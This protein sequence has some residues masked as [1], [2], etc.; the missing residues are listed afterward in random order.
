[1]KSMA[2]IIVIGSGLAGITVVRELRKL[3]AQTPVIMLTSDDG[4]FYSKPNLSNAFAAGKSAAQ[5]VASPRETLAAQLKCDIQSHQIVQ[6]IDLERCVVETSSGPQAYSQLVMAVGAQPIRLP[7]EGSAAEQILSVNNLA[8]Y[9]RFRTALEG[10]ATPFRRVTLLGAGLIGCE[11]ANDLRGA[12]YEVDVVDLA[13]QPLGRLLPP[14]AA[15]Y[16]RRRLEAGGVRFHLGTSVVRVDRA[17][18]GLMLLDREGGRWVTDIV[19]SAVGLRPETA[20]ASA[21]GLEVNRGIM[22]NRQLSASEPNVF[23]VGDC[24]EVDGLNL[25]Y[26]MP[27]MQQ[28]RALAKTLSGTPTDVVYPAMPVAVKTPACPTVV[29]PPPMGLDG[30]W[31][32]N[33]T[34]DG[35]RAL[36]EDAQGVLRGFALIGSAVAEKSALV[37]RLPAM[38]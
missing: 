33:E 9:A 2:P 34:A 23:A 36:F 24:A 12:G 7:I 1:M 29:C 19:L 35:V 14:Q 4:A 13:P 38:F 20:L 18:N 17:E 22:V 3:D 6:S 28:A 15:A 16:F 5:L 37:T 26:V 25:P 32:E 8:D 21:A 30:R 31:S 10:G 11:F 27:I